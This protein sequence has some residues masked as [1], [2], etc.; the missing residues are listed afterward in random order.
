MI[1][2]FFLHFSYHIKLAPP[3]PHLTLTFE[4]KLL[5]C[6]VSQVGSLRTGWNDGSLIEKAGRFFLCFLE[7]F[8]MLTKCVREI[9]H[10]IQL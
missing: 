3:V 7:T 5:T 8:L 4:T 1:F 6:G 2:S 10:E 9:L